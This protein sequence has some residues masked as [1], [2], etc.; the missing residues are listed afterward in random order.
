MCPKISVFTS[1]NPCLKRLAGICFLILFL[2]GC[3]N[4]GDENK[5]K[6][7]PAEDSI[8]FKCTSTQSDRSEYHP[9]HS[10]LSK[11]HIRPNRFL[12][13]ILED[14]GINLQEIDR[15]IKNFKRCI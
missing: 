6:D 15:L 5:L 4:P 10:T 11:G 1:F 8:R 14:Y 2:A 9:I 12:S 7:I 13:E 3:Q